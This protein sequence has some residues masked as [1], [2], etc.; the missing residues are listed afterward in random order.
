MEGLI[1]DYASF[2]MEDTLEDFKR[3]I[4]KYKDFGFCISLAAIGPLTS[5]LENEQSFKHGGG[6]L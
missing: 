2:D 5:M 1:S 4:K 6:L 3:F